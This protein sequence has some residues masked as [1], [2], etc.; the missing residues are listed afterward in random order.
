M[1]NFRQSIILIT[2]LAFLAV[3][4]FFVV[5]VEL[6]PWSHYLSGI[7][8]LLFAAPAFWAATRWLGRRDAVLLFALFAVLALSIETFAIFTGY[9]YGHFGYSDLLGYRFFGSVPWTVAFAWTPLVLAAYMVASRAT[10]F[11]AVRILVTALLLT[12]FDLVLDPV[13]V[14]LGFWRYQEA[15][16]FYG[17]PFSNF[18]GWT[19]TGALAGL[20]MEIFVRLVKPLLP[21][22]A[23]LASS[24]FLILFFWTSAAVFEGLLWP[25]LT[26]AVILAGLGFA[27]ARFHYRFDDMIV[28][29][30]E[31][32]RPIGTAAKVESHHGDTK[33]HRAFSVFL[34]NSAGQLLL[35]QR[36]HSKI[37]WPGV[38]SNSCCGHVMLH[39]RVIDAAKRRLRHELDY[40]NIPL[41]EVLPDFRYRAEKDGVVENEFCP[42][43]VGF[44]D[45][46]PIA[47]PDE[48][49][50]VKWVDWYDFLAEIR[51]GRSRYSPWAIEE[52][53]LLAQNSLFE[54]L[55][56]E[57]T[58]RTPARVRRAA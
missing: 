44:T 25:A 50:D 36:A 8:I 10:E 58:G 42:V 38:W 13:A 34:F 33:L 49:H 29:V 24:G 19:V 2:L 53:E 32:N 14:S 57:H 48:V 3:A 21:V 16:I 43:F 54:E 17:V 12:A 45:A 6:P 35:Q 11:I 31:D 39:E 27:Y 41:F 15:G 4:A 37:T 23:Q 47:N 1:F 7:N 22:P 55:F 30:D 20:V 51:T 28:L 46:D 18:A 52:V 40:R 9:P 5:N 26:G 56:A